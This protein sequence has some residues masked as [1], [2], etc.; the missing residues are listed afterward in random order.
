MMY[1]A[2]YYLRVGLLPCPLGIFITSW[3][4]Y[5]IRQAPT[6]QQ[7]QQITCT[8]LFRDQETTSTIRSIMR[9][10][11]LPIISYV[12]VAVLLVEPQRKSNLITTKVSALN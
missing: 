11:L 12:T 6:K 10:I 2:L 8:I 4:N 9:C 3:E 1:G 5:P 7:K